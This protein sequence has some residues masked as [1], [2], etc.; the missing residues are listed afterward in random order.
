[1]RGLTRDGRDTMFAVPVGG[2]RRGPIGPF[3]MRMKSLGYDLA[4]GG[5]WRKAGDDWWTAEVV[6][7]STGERVKL[8]LRCLNGV[9][10]NRRFA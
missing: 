10:Q 9:W 3:V 4:P 1:M 6:K 8:G 5:V 2:V 7:R